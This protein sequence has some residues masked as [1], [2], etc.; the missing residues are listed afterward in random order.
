MKIKWIKD[1][2]FAHY[3]ES[4]DGKITIDWYLNAPRGSQWKLTDGR[5]LPAQL[6]DCIAW[7]PTLSAAK[8]QANAWTRI[9]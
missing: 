1:P 3:H 8:Y 4:E 2:N 6:E 7:C 5:Y 9:S